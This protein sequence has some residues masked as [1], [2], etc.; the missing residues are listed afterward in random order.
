MHAYVA[1]AKFSEL[2]IKLTPISII[3]NKRVEILLT[4]VEFVRLGTGLGL[5]L[6]FVMVEQ[7]IGLRVS[8]RGSQ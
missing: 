2:P 8:E 4:S 5:A 6:A 3:T 1:F 7:G